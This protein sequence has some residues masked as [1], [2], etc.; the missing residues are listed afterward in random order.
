MIAQVQHKQ[1]ELADLC[2]KYGV[3]RLDLF[4]SAATE[5]EFDADH[6]DLDFLVEFEP[7]ASMGPADQYFGLWE[8]LQSLFSREIHLVSSRALR[9]RYFIESVN[10]T[11]QTLYGS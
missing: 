10:A 2:R 3:R 8:D 5:F 4:G 6:S 11:R 9:N 7:S 1:D